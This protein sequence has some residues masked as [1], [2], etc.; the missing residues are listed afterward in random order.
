ME[1]ANRRLLVLLDLKRGDVFVQEFSRSAAVSVA[2]D[3]VA[4]MQ[5]CIAWLPVHSFLAGDGIAR[6][7]Y[8]TSMPPVLMSRIRRSTAPP[9]AC[10][11]AQ[12][13]RDRSPNGTGLPTTPLYLRAPELRLPPAIAVASNTAASNR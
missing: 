10:W 13:R 2:S 3:L 5:S 9:D 1:R 4:W 8:R 12:W 6:R 11:V 7:P